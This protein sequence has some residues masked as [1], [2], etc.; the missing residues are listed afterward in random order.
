[1]DKY[2]RIAENYHKHLF[3][4]DYLRK[5]NWI[6]TETKCIWEDQGPNIRHIKLLCR[7]VWA[8]AKML[9]FMDEHEDD[10]IEDMPNI[11]YF[12][13]P[14]YEEE[15]VEEWEEG[16]LQP[17]GEEWDEGELLPEGQPQLQ[18]WEPDVG[19]ESDEDYN[20]STDEDEPNCN[21]ESDWVEYPLDVLE[22]ID[23]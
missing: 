19:Y 1:M 5:G 10:W 23:L 16:E 17:E 9:Q 13:P 8:H 14:E 3:T 21:E 18:D 20:Y 11:H 22:D 7:N 6:W 2:L 4:V 15:E 12:Y